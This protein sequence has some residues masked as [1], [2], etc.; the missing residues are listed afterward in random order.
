MIGI[1]KYLYKICAYLTQLRNTNKQFSL[2]GNCHL[3]C[4]AIWQ[5]KLC[6]GYKTMTISEKP[7]SL[8][9]LCEYVSMTTLVKHSVAQPTEFWPTIKLLCKR[10]Q[11]YGILLAKLFWPTV[12]KKNVLVIKKNFW[13]SRLKAENL[14]NFWD[15]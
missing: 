3:F 6:Q 8:L 13:N 5:Q 15:H 7:I 4:F 12:R 11:N 1:W 2:P 9:M 14:Q 10:L